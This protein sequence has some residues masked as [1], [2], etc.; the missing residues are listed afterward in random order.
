MKVTRLISILVIT[1]PLV[2][3]PLSANSER[4]ERTL[5]RYISQ[6]CNK[7]SARPSTGIAGLFEIIIHN[8]RSHRSSECEQNT[9]ARLALDEKYFQASE[10]DRSFRDHTKEITRTT[11]GPDIP[12]V[13]N[14]RAFTDPGDRS[15]GSI[16]LGKLNGYSNLGQ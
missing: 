16:N 4:Q 12:G 13:P 9:K 8:D 14:N 10:H 2:C 6:H 15:K 1:G 7:P 3:S 5:S 11:W